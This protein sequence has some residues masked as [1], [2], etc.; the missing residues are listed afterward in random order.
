M[1]S[2]GELD[3]LMERIFSQLGLGT[4]NLTKGLQANQADSNNQ[5]SQRLLPKLSVQKTLVILGLIG[6]VFEVKSILFDRDQLV[7]I[8]LEGS[9]KR[10]TK[11]DNCLDEIGA[12]PFD[13]VLRAILG[14]L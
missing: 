1:F 14:R 2:S 8:L 10:R 12:M 6:G 7:N 13:E 5:D 3:P 4:G 9:L 11:L